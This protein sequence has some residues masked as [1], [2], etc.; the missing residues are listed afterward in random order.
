MLEAGGAAMIRIQRAYEPAAP[1]DGERVLVDRV[2]P[3]G[4]SRQ[5]LH[6]GGWERELAPSTAL[7][8]WFGHDPA[9]WDEFVRRYRE[10]LQ[11]P[12]QQARL[13]AQAERA[14]QQTV[15]LVYGARDEEHNQAIMLR[16]VLAERRRAG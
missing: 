4:V 11:A 2:W 1:G 10:E 16:D 9:R 12:E 8:R 5:A 6:I 13:D 14:R 7:R 15:T 3:R